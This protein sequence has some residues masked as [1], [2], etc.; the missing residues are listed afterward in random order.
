MPDNKLEVYSDLETRPFSTD[1]AILIW[2]FQEQ[3][4]ITAFSDF[5]CVLVTKTKGASGSDSNSKKKFDSDTDSKNA[6]NGVG[7]RPDSDSGV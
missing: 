2:V 7:F 3:S 1:G 4:K 6:Q 5:F